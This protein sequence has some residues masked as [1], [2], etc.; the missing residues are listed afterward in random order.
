MLSFINFLICRYNNRELFLFKEENMT[1]FII[2]LHEAKAGM[3]LSRDVFNENAI[4]VVPEQTILTDAMID[5]MA[6]HNIKN[7]HIFVDEEYVETESAID[8]PELKELKKDYVKKIEQ[9]K[10]VFTDLEDGNVQEKVEDIS[11]SIIK[12]E[13]STGDMLRCMTQIRATDEYI[14]SH[15]LNVASVCY[16]I[17]TWMNLE[18]NT[19]KDLVLTGLMHD[20][21]KTKISTDILHKPQLTEL[22]KKEISN[23]P[24]YGYN[25]LKENTN[26]S[27]EI[28]NGVLMHQEREDGSGYPRGLKSDQISMFGK[29]IAVADIYSTITLDRLYK[30][31]DTPFAVFSL[32]EATSSQKFDP[33]ATYILITNIAKYYIGDKVLLS[34]G[35]RG[36]VIFIDDEFVSRPLIKSYDDEIIDLRVQKKIIIE[37]ML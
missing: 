3:K 27:D 11:I 19:I 12:S 24:T 28:C 1:E 34:N 30:R 18:Q 2:S 5:R 37:K 36:T 33:L 8:T 20:I 16:L 7:F 17:G 25:I 14:Y 26:F 32:L 21:G 4:I 31:T 13:K 6:L 29:I 9:I 22:E 10:S 23:H 15:S 35:K